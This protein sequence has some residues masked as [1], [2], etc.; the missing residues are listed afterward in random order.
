MITKLEIE[1][2]DIKNPVKIVSFSFNQTKSSVSVNLV[3]TY[4]ASASNIPFILEDYSGSGTVF[5]YEGNIA[6]YLTNLQYSYLMV[7]SNNE[8]STEDLL[9][10]NSDG[11]VK[12]IIDYQ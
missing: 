3:R 11:I 1:F 12:I 5:K 10:Y 7:K 9:S 4:A 8:L 2:E 6:S